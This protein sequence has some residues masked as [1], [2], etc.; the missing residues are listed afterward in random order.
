MNSRHRFIL[1][2]T[3]IPQSKKGDTYNQNNSAGQASANTF[4]V[5]LPG[6]IVASSTIN[7]SCSER[8][9]RGSCAHISELNLGFVGPGH[10]M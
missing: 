5:L 8:L 1:A 3:K 10:V 6:S 9:T 4:G 7:T 2:G